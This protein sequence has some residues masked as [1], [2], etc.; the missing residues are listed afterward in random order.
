[1][2]WTASGHRIVEQKAVNGHQ[3]TFRVTMNEKVIFI[4]LRLENGKHFTEKVGVM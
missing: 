1:M 4:M 2:V 3:F